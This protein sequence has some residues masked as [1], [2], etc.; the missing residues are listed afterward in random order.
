MRRQPRGGPVAIDGEVRLAISFFPTLVGD[1]VRI[2]N[3]PGFSDQPFLT[4]EEARVQVALLPLLSG[5][6]QFTEIAALSQAGR[7]S[8]LVAL[9]RAEDPGRRTADERRL[10]VE[11]EGEGETGTYGGSSPSDNKTPAVTPPATATPT[12]VQNHQIGRASCR[13]RV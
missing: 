12:A 4:A 10:L 5:E 6:L 1:R 11:A 8:S 7:D 13:E 9:L 2:A 3:P